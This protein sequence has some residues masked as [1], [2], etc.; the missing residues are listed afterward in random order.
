MRCETFCKFKLFYNYK[1]YSKICKNGM[2]HIPSLCAFDKGYMEWIKMTGDW[3]NLYARREPRT[4]KILSRL[5][6]H[7]HWE[8]DGRYAK[9]THVETLRH[10][11]RL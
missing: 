7:V 9:Y 6:V 4:V 5:K 1:F 8:W 10:K 2:V 3:R 11:L